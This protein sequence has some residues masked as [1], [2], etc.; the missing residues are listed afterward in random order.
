MKVGVK[1]G[2]PISPVTWVNTRDM[3]LEAERLG[4]D[5][6]W[7]EDHHYEPNGGPLDAWAALA[8]LAAITTDVE[9]SPIVA[10]LNFYASPVVLAHKIAT[11]HEISDGR[12]IVGIGAGDADEN[13][14]LG[15]PSDHVVTRFIEKFEVIRR[16]LA[17]ERFDF[18]GRFIQLEDA[19]LPTTHRVEWRRGLPSTGTT[20]PLAVRWMTGSTAPRMLAATVPHVAGWATHWSN[21]NFWNDPG[22]L[23][24]TW[25]VLDAAAADA[26]RDPREIWRAAEAWVQVTAAQGLPIAV[27]DDLVPVSGGTSSIVEYLHRCEEAGLDH[28]VVLVDPQTVPAVEDLARAMAEYRSYS[29]HPTR[30]TGY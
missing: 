23:A 26:G 24:E 18:D 15:L 13:T 29:A 7:I 11:I 17:G 4:F 3:A 19:F 2:A 21:D 1:V 25:P 5:S 30:P 8:A 22:R 12:L 6:V 20:T 28:L 27:P 10:S 9:L 16:L 14:R